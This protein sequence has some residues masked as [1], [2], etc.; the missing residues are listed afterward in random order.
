ME[1]IPLQIPAEL[2]DLGIAGILLFVLGHLL[3]MYKRKDKELTQ[4]NEKVLEAFNENT[5][6][7]TKHAETLNNINNSLNVNTKATERTAN[8]MDRVAQTLQ[9]QT[10]NVKMLSNEIMRSTRGN[11]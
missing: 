5:A 3:G 4:I 10:E 9:S 6:V 7:L 11:K 8:S 2:I 1:S